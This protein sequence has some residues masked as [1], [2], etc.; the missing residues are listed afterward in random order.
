MNSDLSNVRFYA[1]SSLEIPILSWVETG[2]S[3][4]LVWLRLPNAINANSSI[5]IYMTV[6]QGLGFDG[7]NAGTAPNNTTPYALY[8]NGA[9]VFNNYW[10]FAGT[11]VP[12][13]IT[14]APNASLLPTFNNGVTTTQGGSSG[15]ECG[16]Y[17]TNSSYGLDPTT[18]WDF[19][20]SYTDVPGS[21][22]AYTNTAI[23][24]NSFADFPAVAFIGDGV[25]NSGSGIYLD[26]ASG[27]GTGTLQMSSGIM[28]LCTIYWPSSSQAAFQLNYGTPEVLSGAPSTQMPVGAYSWRSAS[29]TTFVQ[30]MRQRAYPPNGVMPTITFM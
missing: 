25:N 26:F 8:D 1:D 27:H 18:V 3:S 6:A 9:S 14:I 5:L 30:W 23:G 13:N 28:Y 11:S 2:G 10:N 19:F 24:F 7:I 22:N 4:P 29:A 21:S 20:A 12:A 17:T 16:W 15:S